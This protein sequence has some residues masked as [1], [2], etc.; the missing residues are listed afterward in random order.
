MS[1][2]NILL[3]PSRSRFSCLLS[4]AVLLLFSHLTDA[5]TLTGANGR[6]VNFAGIKDARK[7]GVMVQMEPDGDLIPIRWEKLDLTA[8]KDEN[9]LVYAAYELTR[10][11]KTIDINLGTFAPEGMEH[12]EGKPNTPVA[13][14]GRWP[15]WADVRAGGV[16][17]LLQMPLGKPRG[18]LLIA[19]GDDGNSFRFLMGH[20][21][22]SGVWGEFQNKYQLALLCYEYGYDEATFEIEKMDDFGFAD[23]RSGEQIL[24]AINQLAVKIGNPDIVD[25]PIAIYGTDRVGA[26]LSYSFTQWKPER[27]MAG[28][29]VKGAFFEADPT[30]ASAK[31]PMVLAWGQYCN[32]HEIWKSEDVP[33]K[34]FEDHNSMPLNWT[35]AM[36]Y[37]GRSEI[38]HLS[39]HFAREVLKELIELRIPDKAP[40]PP[41]EPKSDEE[42]DDKKKEEDK[43][44]EE[45]EKPEPPK[46]KEIDRSKGYI[47]VVKTGET[48]KVESADE[49]PGPGETFIPTLKISQMWRDYVKGEFELPP[50]PPQPDQ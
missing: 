9:A 39:E 18:I 10:E 29:A 23:K 46:I 44:P 20:Q 32:K 5:I 35:N 31:V 24:H 45:P 26:A 6:K 30:E 27:V 42:G 43:K 4:V 47:G 19:K 17:F 21:K 49:L 8:L 41:P 15:G 14:K 33:K 38:D 16:Q 3:L 34:V 50:P 1:A 2:D 12:A 28:V 48:R 40:D 36:E 13:P 37:R 11:G 7:G 22:G 25:L